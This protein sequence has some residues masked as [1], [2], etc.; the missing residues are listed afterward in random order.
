MQRFFRWFFRDID[1]GE[2]ENYLKKRGEHGSYLVRESRSKPGNF[3]LAVR[4]ACSNYVNFPLKN[5]FYFLV[6]D[7]LLLIYR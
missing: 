1:R 3:V 7:S 6:A 4:Y 2:A 5:V